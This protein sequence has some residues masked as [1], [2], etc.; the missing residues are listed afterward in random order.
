MWP[1]LQPEWEAE[2]GTSEGVFLLLLVPWA[3]PNVWPGVK[4]AQEAIW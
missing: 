3:G 2:P 1:P 4:K